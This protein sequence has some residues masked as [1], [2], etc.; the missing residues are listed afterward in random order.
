MIRLS[1]ALG[2]TC[3]LIVAHPV[4]HGHLSARDVI[5][6]SAEAI[7]GVDRLRGVRAVRVDEIGG[8]YMVSTITRRDAPPRAISQ[9]ITTLRSAADS[10]LR[11]TMVQTFPM[12]SGALATV[13]VASHGVVGTV[14]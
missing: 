3:S 5:V 4:A 2:I 9:M 13:T 8:E 10:S 12:R 7:G 1:L 14:R 6:Q 11:R